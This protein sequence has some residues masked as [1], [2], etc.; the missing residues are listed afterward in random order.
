VWDGA[1]EDRDTEKAMAGRGLEVWRMRDG[2]IA[3]WDAA[4]NVWEQRSGRKTSW[5]GAAAGPAPHWVLV[6]NHAGL[7]KGDRSRRGYTVECSWDR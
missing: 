7:T 4:F 6:G 3:V 1:W 2:M 5:A